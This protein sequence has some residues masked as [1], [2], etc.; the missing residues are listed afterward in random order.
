MWDFNDI[1]D[2]VLFY[3]NFSTFKW[4]FLNIKLHCCNHTIK[5]ISIP[6]HLL[7]FQPPSPLVK[8]N[9]HKLFLMLRLLGI[10][11]GFLCNLKTNRLK[12]KIRGKNPKKL[13]VHIG[14]DLRNIV[15]TRKTWAQTHVLRL[16][17]PLCD[18]ERIWHRLQTKWIFIWVFRRGE[19]HMSPFP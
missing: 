13:S 5:P 8:F 15:F 12:K 4:S 17:L 11:M 14:L 7:R 19:T 16:L 9:K 6:K 2:M 18:S 3:I 10:L 1:V